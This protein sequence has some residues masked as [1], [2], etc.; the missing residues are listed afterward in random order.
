MR[1]LITKL[2]KNQQDYT[3]QYRFY[4][5]VCEEKYVM[6]AH[7]SMTEKIKVWKCIDLCPLQVIALSLAGKENSQNNN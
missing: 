2:N 1:N 6:Y 4:F 7:Y 3:L 5:F